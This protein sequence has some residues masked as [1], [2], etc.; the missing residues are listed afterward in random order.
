MKQLFK[1]KLYIDGDDFYGFVSDNYGYDLSYGLLDGL[2]YIYNEN[3]E[4]DIDLNLEHYKDKIDDFDYDKIT[5]I[6]IEN[7]TNDTFNIIG[8]CINVEEIKFEN[9]GL[10]YI[11]DHLIN[12]KRIELIN[13][14]NIKEI[15]NTLINLRSLYLTHCNNIIKIPETLKETLIN[16]QLN[17]CD[18]IKKVDKLNNLQTLQIFNCNIKEISKS[19]I[20]LKSL[21]LDH[22]ENIKEIPN[23]LINLKFIDLYYCKSIRKIPNTLINLEKI[24]LNAPKFNIPNNIK[25]LPNIKIYK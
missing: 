20:N 8:R 4:E 3:G 6:K 21:Y 16:L 18:K 9:V 14:P 1:N 13:C 22:C 15:P 24:Y 19:C 7:I 5:T 25:N 23:T 11:P 12:L 17:Y 2:N 10:K